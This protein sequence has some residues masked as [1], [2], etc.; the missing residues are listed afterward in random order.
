MLV[1]VCVV[2]MCVY[3]SVCVCVCCVC[4]CVCM[5]VYAFVSVCTG[6]CMCICV[7]VRVRVRLFV[8]V[9]VRVCVFGQAA[10]RRKQDNLRT[11]IQ[12]KWDKGC[13]V[14]R[15]PSAALQSGPHLSPRLSPSLAHGGRKPY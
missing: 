5:C 1:Y 9:C 10:R 13:L 7:R 4:L 12:V 11:Y 3:V 15:E 8:C 14:G 6:T 2:C